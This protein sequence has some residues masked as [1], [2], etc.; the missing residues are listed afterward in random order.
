MWNVDVYNR[1]IYNAQ[2]FLQSNQ[3]T[4]SETNVDLRARLRFASWKQLE[5]SVAVYVN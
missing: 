5:R 1:S 4:W 3:K 2:L